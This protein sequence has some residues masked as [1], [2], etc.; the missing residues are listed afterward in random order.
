MSALSIRS[1]SEAVHGF[2]SG[3]G[4]RG[5][6]WRRLPREAPLL[7]IAVCGATYGVVMASYNGLAGERALMAVFGGVKV[8]LLFLATLMLAIPFFYVLNLLAGVGDDF[9]IVWRGLTDYQL[10]IALQLLALAPVTLFV[11]LVSGDYRAA[12]AWSTLVFAV[13]SWNARRSLDTCYAPLISRNSVHE[14]LRKLWFYLYAFVG[15]QM[16][17]DLRPFV[18]HPSMP[19][20]FFR[21]EIGNAYVE[22]V[23]IIGIMFT[24]LTEGFRKLH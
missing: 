10:S 24:E 23:K 6:E 18:G 8:P 19:V 13:V 14:P 11:N 2:L 15:I 4:R 21:P 1:W 16:G 3:G 5:V 12:Q 22:V 17:W 20:Q 9:K 7:V